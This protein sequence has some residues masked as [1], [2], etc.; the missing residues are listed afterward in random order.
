MPGAVAALSVNL[1]AVKERQQAGGSELS[2][3]NTRRAWSVLRVRL[4]GDVVLASRSCSA[5]YS[6][7]Y[8]I[9]VWNH[10]EAVY[11]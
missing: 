8:H 4:A 5:L 11:A 1:R 7:C 6:D 3:G 10:T 2:L 9:A